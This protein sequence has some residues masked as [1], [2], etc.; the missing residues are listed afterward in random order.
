MERPVKM[1]S[2]RAFARRRVIMLGGAT[3][4]RWQGVVVDKVVDE[5]DR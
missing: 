3:W 4:R 2:M 5:D 1:A